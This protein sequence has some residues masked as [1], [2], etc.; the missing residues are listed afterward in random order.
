[1]QKRTLATLSLTIT[2]L[3]QLANL[4]ASE[5]PNIVVIFTDD[6]GYGDLACYGSQKVQTPSIDK[7]AREVPLSD[8]EAAV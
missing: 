3:L 5:K 7:M 2:F 1:M 4:S 6:L 8:D